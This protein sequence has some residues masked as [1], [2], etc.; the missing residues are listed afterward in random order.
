MEDVNINSLEDTIVALSTPR[1][2][3]AIAV[4]RLSGE[5]SLEIASEIVE[6]SEKLLEQQ[7]HRIARARLLFENG[8]LLDD[9]LYSLFLKPNSYTGENVVEFSI[10][11]SPF[12]I[13]NVIDRCCREGARPAEPGEF[14]QRAFLN[15]RIDLAQAEAVADLI[16]SEG[17][18]A[19]RAAISQKEGNLS[20]RIESI[21]DNLLETVALLETEIDFSDEDIPI[22]DKGELLGR[23]AIIREILVE[24]RDT[25]QRGRMLREG[26]RVVI[27][28][29]AN[30]GK[31]TLFNALLKEDRAIVH[32]QPGTTRDSVSARIEWG[33]VGIRLVDTAGLGDHLKGP[34]KAAVTKARAEVKQA[35]LVLWVIDLSESDHELPPADII[36]RMLLVGNKSDISVKC[37]IPSEFKH[38]MV[39]ALKGT[40]LTKITDNVLN[41]LSLDSNSIEIGSDT[42]TRERH[43]RA[44]AEA[45][46]SVENAQSALQKERGTELIIAD[47]W[48]SAKHLSSIMGKMTA[49][50]VLNRIFGEFC[51]GK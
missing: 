25:Y 29:A 5:R 42:L 34:D 23:M 37:E 4:V 33:G 46:E 41:M 13:A 10:H 19:H 51:I 16:A 15:G 7:T 18:A 11:C 40:G 48:E 49:D 9:A 28:G 44:V 6:N 24:L 30:V 20:R 32:E 35:D 31:S 3:G 22:V 50:D 1:G 43:Y 14:T 45:V 8:Q 21:H 47:L 2:R 26:V 12:I 38:L 36:D 39:S 27:A 17:E